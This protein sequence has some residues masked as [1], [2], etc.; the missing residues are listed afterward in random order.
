VAPG[1]TSLSLLWSQPKN[2]LASSSNSY[3][4]AAGQGAASTPVAGQGA[5]S[6]QLVLPAGWSQMSSH[7]V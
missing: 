6:T 1:Y 7:I 5:A 2:P 4:P 3:V